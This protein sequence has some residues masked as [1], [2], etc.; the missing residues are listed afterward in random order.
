MFAPHRLSNRIRHNVASVDSETRPSGSVGAPIEPVTPQSGSTRPDGRASSQVFGYTIAVDVDLEQL[1]IPRW[2]LQ[3]RGCGYVL[4]GLPEH[5]CPE[6]GRPVIMGELVQTWTHLREPVFD[7]GELPFP[8]F[9]LTCST[10]DAPLAGATEHHCPSCQALFNPQASVP[11]G[12]WYKIPPAMLED[13]PAQ[14]VELTL[15]E[16]LIPYVRR[17]R[18][19]L[20]HI[21][22]VSPH[23]EAHFEIPRAF[24]F[25]L[26]AALR[27][28]HLATADPSGPDWTCPNCQEPNPPTFQVCWNCHQPSDDNA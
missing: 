23:A 26:L 2:N 17:E 22:G 8:D 24:Y 1:P 3:C 11:Q 28:Q 10:C 6:C 13:L 12:E 20:S 14:V 7:G 9:G 5:R 25:D 19:D 21:Y 16:D 15:A 18:R 27:R 4:N